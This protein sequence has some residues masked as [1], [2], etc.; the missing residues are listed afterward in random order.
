MYT[1]KTMGKYIPTTRQLS[2]KDRGVQLGS[3]QRRVY[4]FGDAQLVDTN[5]TQ[6]RPVSDKYY[7]E[8]VRKS[9]FNDRTMRCFDYKLKRSSGKV[10][11]K[12]PRVG[13][14]ITFHEPFLQTAV[15]R[16]CVREIYLKRKERSTGVCIVDQWHW[17]ANQSDFTRRDKYASQQR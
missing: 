12:P 7:A 3:T 16:A 14:Y 11:S 8:L 9:F 4:N 2:V 10:F 15:G 13:D 17:F 1:K 6:Y 5:E